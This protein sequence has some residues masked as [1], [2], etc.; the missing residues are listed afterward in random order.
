ML[1]PI[2]LT[3]QNSKPR[4]SVVSTVG[5]ATESLSTEA[6]KYEFITYIFHDFN[7]VKYFE[8]D[9]HLNEKVY[10]YEETEITG[11]DIYLVEQWVID[12]K[13]GTVVATF[14]G[15]KESRVKVK[16][17]TIQKKQSK[18]YP[19]KFQEYLNELVL[20]HSKTKPVDK[21]HEAGGDGNDSTTTEKGNTSN[22]SDVDGGKDDV[23]FSEQ[24][25][26]ITNLSSLP[27]N[28][29]LIPIPGGDPREVEV[30]CTINLNLKKLNCSGRSISLISETTS[31]AI[32]DKFRQMYKIYNT[33]IPFRFAVRELVNVIQ[34]CLFYFDLLDAKY[35]DGLLCSKTEE[36]IKSWWNLIGLPHFNYK[37]NSRAGIL[38]TNSVAAIISLVLSVRLRL[39]LVGGCDVPK[40]PFDFENMMLSIGQFQK[41]FKLEKKRKLDLETLN[42]LF[43]TTN[44]RLSHSKNPGIDFGGTVSP[45]LEYQAQSTPSKTST[46]VS[47]SKKNRH[48]Y[49]KE[50]KKLT[51][52]VR[53]TV[54]DHINAAGGREDDDLDNSISGAKFRTK[55][56]KYSEPQNPFEI[57]T[58]DLEVLVKNSI[59]GKTLIRLFHGVKTSTVSRQEYGSSSLS[60]HLKPEKSFLPNLSRYNSTSKLPGY[61][62]T[63]V[64]L[65]DRIS[66]NQ[67]GLNSGLTSSIA[68][69]SRYSRG[70]NKVRLGLLSKKNNR[71]LEDY[72]PTN[73]RR[74]STYVIDI[75]D[76]QDKDTSTISHSLV[77][78]LLKLP[79]EEESSDIE[80]KHSNPKVCPHDKHHSPLDVILK[81][82]NR[83]NS[84][85]FNY[86]NYELNLNLLAASQL[87]DIKSDARALDM[88]LNLK[89]SKSCSLLDDYLLRYRETPLNTLVK[90]SDSY[91]KTLDDKIKFDTIRKFYDT[92][93]SADACTTMT[94]GNIRRKYKLLNLELLRLG[95]AHRQMT[96]NKAK[97]MDEDLSNNLEYQLRTLRSTLDRVIYETRI[98][99]KR[100]NELQETSKTFVANVETENTRM[101]KIIQH[102]ITSAKF[103]QT[104]HDE[105]RAELIYK[106]TSS[107]DTV[108]SLC[109]PATSHPAN[110]G[111]IAMILLAVYTVVDYFFSLIQFD[112]SNMNLDRIRNVWIKL[113]PNRSFINKAYSIIG[114]TTTWESVSVNDGARSETTCDNNDKDKDNTN[115]SISDDSPTDESLLEKESV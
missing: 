31:D 24:V 17:I 50:L 104:F 99:G 85:P 84:Y 57:E 2:V 13:I 60:V 20:N 105:E 59:H 91:L 54:Q 107:H 112:T 52:V 37:P 19:L 36:A 69:L 32:V 35:A 63:F 55:I 25:C 68:D 86:K 88:N 109:E 113:D 29:N 73:S 21:I 87:D 94:N 82:L 33:N 34:I 103:N 79:N 48:Y 42:K 27:S 51:N 111:L 93:V 78:S 9:L 70:L 26:F 5:S 15:N 8:K 64:S 58:L 56:A 45:E 65:R 12:R 11:L 108:A 1:Y 43:T 90:F 61:E 40:D 95:N 10:F 18:N 74:G 77:D 80:S 39:N 83:R 49:S 14:T 76:K 97:V 106:L 38:P 22:F 98:V 46:P 7:A 66:S 81:N 75:T 53:T 4:G 44:A 23:N 110:N 30:N 100:I 47:L 101:N 16:K 3:A 72:T 96:T 115:I 92:D 89:R 28:L 67:E 102:L 6:G 71:R 114:R 62:Y 41:Q